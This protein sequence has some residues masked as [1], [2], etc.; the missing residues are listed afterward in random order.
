MPRLAGLE[1]LVA[2][3][4]AE[5]P[6]FQASGGQSLPAAVRQLSVPDAAGGPICSAVGRL[7]GST[8]T[9][10]DLVAAA[11]QAID[12]TDSVVRA[13]SFLDLDGARRRATELDRHATRASVSRPLAGLPIGVK[14][15][16]DVAG[17]PTGAGSRQ[18]AMAVPA[19]TDSPIVGQL[20]AAGAIVI[21]KCTTH[22]Y[23]FGGITPPTTNPAD[24]LRIP[25]GSSGGSA[26]AVA[27]GHVPLA[28]GTDTAGSVR[29]PASYCGV[30]GFVPS[31]GR[32]SNEGVTPLSW[33][34]DRVGLLT[35]TAADG[36]YVAA[37]L[38]LASGASSE[39]G[40]DGVRVGVLA[41]AFD[42]P[43]EPP[44]RQAVKAALATITNSGAQLSVVEV[45]HDRLSIA[46]SMALIVAESAEYHR[47]RLLD[48]PELFSDDVLASLR[49]NDQLMAADLVRAHRVR[50]LIAR[51]WRSVFDS[52]DLVVGP[53]MPLTAPTSAQAAMGVLQIEESLVSLVDAHLRY[54]AVANV[55]GLPAATQP[56][57]RD[58]RGL[59]IGLQWLAAPGDDHLIMRALVAFEH[60]SLRTSAGR[61]K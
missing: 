12:R 31:P 54:P 14:D 40:F 26:A 13:W 4:L 9:A 42:A 20:R 1:A 7:A 28:V 53:T 29:I 10:G 21:G 33:S 8:V 16:V 45:P 18:R 15:L 32:I 58:D 55:A 34:L 22:E 24:P 43:L 25:G 46:C 17:M 19:E 57:G 35:A 49:L 50:E 23:A 37:A 36:A 6:P 47:S 51:E 44:V 59:P 60:L 61:A 3:E 30:V 2:L 11:E 56:C 5:L 41:D 48:S 27:S 39:A 38:G 52:V